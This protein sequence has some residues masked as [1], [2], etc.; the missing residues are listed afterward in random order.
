[1]SDPEFRISM[2]AD[3][4]CDLNGSIPSTS[5]CTTI[6]EKFYGFNP[7]T[8]DIEPPFTQ[9]TITVMA[10]DNLPC[11]LPR[12]ASEGFGKHLIERVMPD[13]IE[14]DTSGLIERATICKN[15]KLMPRFEYLADYVA[16]PDTKVTA[17]NK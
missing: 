8:G 6:E 2:I 5:K 17:G 1:M 12:D 11:E 10:I 15:G 7:I 9:G 14:S 4:T 16:G 3:V 13:M